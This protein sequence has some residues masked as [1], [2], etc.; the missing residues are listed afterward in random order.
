MIESNLDRTL[1]SLW[2]MWRVPRGAGAST[3]LTEP[4]GLIHEAGGVLGN[5]KVEMQG[6]M[7]QTKAH[8]VDLR[9]RDG[10]I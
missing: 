5:L 2:G 3:A 1:G 9:K 4:W 7:S 8:P 10:G 6:R